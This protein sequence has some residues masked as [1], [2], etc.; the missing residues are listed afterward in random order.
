MMDT[1]ISV[2][3]GL[4]FSGVLVGCTYTC[5]CSWT[6]VVDRFACTECVYTEGCDCMRTV[7]CVVL[8]VFHCYTCGSG[9]ID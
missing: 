9:S 8:S 1:L 2:L 4:N 7:H 3:W 5:T 6:V